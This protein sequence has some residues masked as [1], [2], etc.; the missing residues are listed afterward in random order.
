MSASDTDKAFRLV[1]AKTGKPRVQRE[2]AKRVLK[3]AKQTRVPIPEV[4]VKITSFSKSGRLGDH[5]SYISRNGKNPVYDAADSELGKPGAEQREAL[6]DH[7]RGVEDVDRKGHKNKRLT[8]NLIL[9]MPPGTPSE[10]FRAS[11][12]EM[13]AEQFANYDYIYTFHDDTDQE[14]AHVSVP[15]MGFDG[16]R[17]NPR[18]GDLAQWRERFA[19][20]LERNGIPAN[21][22]PAIAQNRQTL[23]RESRRYPQTE[24]SGFGQAPYQF[25]SNAGMSF[26]ATLRNMDTGKERTYWGKD[27]ERIFGDGKYALGDQIRLKVIPP[28]PRD[29]EKPRNGPRSVYWSAQYLP[30]KDKSAVRAPL[31]DPTHTKIVDALGTIRLAYQRAS[32]AEGQ[33]L[34]E[35]YAKARFGVVL[36]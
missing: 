19:G 2:H 27:L 21:A 15:M 22:M 33:S 14:H 25:G 3:K 16:K 36:D 26:F 9:S 23:R 11:V 1:F 13:L 29:A 6:R 24:L 31:N 5:L 8:C 18:K 12:R 28:D 4:M 30:M 10:A 32:D 34:V 17:L 7:E 20:A 35:D